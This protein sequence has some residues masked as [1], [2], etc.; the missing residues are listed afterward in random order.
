MNYDTI[1]QMLRYGLIAGGGWLSS[2]GYASGE[3]VETVIGA[4]GAI[5]SVGWGIYVK[6]GTKAVSAETAARPDV[7][8]VSAATGSIEQPTPPEK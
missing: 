7:P 1:W 8:T 2:K 5:L 3:Q 6:A 4:I